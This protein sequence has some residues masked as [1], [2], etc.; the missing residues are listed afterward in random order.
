MSLL[1]RAALAAALTSTALT[2]G[3]GSASAAGNYYGTLAVSPGAGKVVESTDQPSR[4]AADARAIR[5]CG[6]FDC[7]IMV[8]FVDG[9]GAVARGADGQ[10]AADAAPSRAEA[11]RLAIAKLGESAP[12]FPDLGSAAPR[13]ATIALSSC[14]KNAS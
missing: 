12:P 2:M 1:G 11:E 14:T 9:C 5:D 7:Q 4:V 3:A 13:A 6:V 10:F 8:R